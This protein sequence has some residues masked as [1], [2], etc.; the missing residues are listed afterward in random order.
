[1]HNNADSRDTH[2]ALPFLYTRFLPNWEKTFV[3][4]CK[5]LERDS[6][7]KLWKHSLYIIVVACVGA[8][9]NFCAEFSHRRRAS[10]RFHRQNKLGREATT[11]TALAGEV[12]KRRGK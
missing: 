2:I 10:M 12:N 3:D 9:A 5:M 6:E 4:V 8:E 1:M 7:E 11:T